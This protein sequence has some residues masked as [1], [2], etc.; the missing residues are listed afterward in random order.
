MY[1]EGGV[2]NNANRDAAGSD[3]NEGELGL[4]GGRNCYNNEVRRGIRAR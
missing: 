1:P 4:N 2:K 3:G